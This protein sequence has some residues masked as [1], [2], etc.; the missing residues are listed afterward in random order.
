MKLI[1]LYIDSFG[2][3]SDF[4][5]DFTK[6]INSI[7][8]ENGWGKT[9]LTVFIKAMLYGLSKNDR[10]MYTPW[11]SLSTFGGYLILEANGNEYRIERQFNPSK[12][13]SDT[14]KAYDLKT[15][16]QVNIDSN[17]GELLL[18]LNENSFE[19]S[20]FIPEKNLNDGFCLR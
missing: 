9:T 1:S 13:S 4:S 12:A 18:N 6:E 20:V 3:L 8:E 11:K 7:Y 2:K 16:K 15:N 19:R 14:F 17:V 5:F 10:A